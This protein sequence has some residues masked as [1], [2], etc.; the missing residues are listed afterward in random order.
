MSPELKEQLV[1][2][3]ESF[4]RGI[5][6]ARRRR[7]RSQTDADCCQRVIDGLG[8]K[9]EAAEKLLDGHE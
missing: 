5:E 3:R 7:D 9:L 1:K 8:Q 4:K 2:L 6:E